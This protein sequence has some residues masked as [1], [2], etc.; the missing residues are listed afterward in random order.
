MAES[1][2]KP[3]AIMI[4]LGKES[5]KPSSDEE[6]DES[7]DIDVDD[8]LVTAAKAVR[9]AGSDEEY[10]KALKGFVKLCGGY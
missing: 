3:N 8:D 7:A 1:K 5:K 2:E 10:A 6:D 9:G 4:A